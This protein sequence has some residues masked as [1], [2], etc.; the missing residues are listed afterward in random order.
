MKIDM[1]TKKT[2]KRPSAKARGLH[3]ILLSTVTPAQAKRLE[4]ASKAANESRVCFIIDAALA[5]ADKVL[6]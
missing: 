5:R 6:G 3:P 1:T 2:T 4:R